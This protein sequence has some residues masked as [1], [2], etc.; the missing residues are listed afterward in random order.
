MI[1]RAFA[2]TALCGAAGYAVLRAQ[3]REQRTVPSPETFTI[4]Q[5]MRA[6]GP[7]AGP[8]D[9][10]PLGGLRQAE[11]DLA[12]QVV[13]EVYGARCRLHEPVVPPP[14]AWV[15]PRAQ[16]DADAL[17][18]FLVDH[19]P[20]DS[21][22]LIAITD[23][24]MFAAGRPYVFGYGHLRDRVAV[25]SMHRMEERYYGRRPRAPLEMTRLY[26]ALV[27]ELGHTAGNPHC[28][29]PG[30]VMREVADLSVLDG[31]TGLYCPE[32]MRRTRCELRVAPLAPEAQF[33]LGGALL[34]RRSF[35]RAVMVLARAA[36]GDP[37]NAIYQ[38]DLGVAL[39][40]RGDRRGALAAFQRAR[41]L[42]PDLPQPGYN[43]R[44]L[45]RGIVAPWEAETAET[46]ATGSGPGPSS[47]R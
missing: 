7:A 27:H 43:L 19:F 41:R 8:I 40:R 47:G 2:W 44:L 24:D 13:T 18:G 6:S 22:R 1:R 15:R 11:L 42:R 26:K 45:E 30:C 14:A 31:L 23:Q 46:T 32:C 12:C 33:S 34:R 36:N 20:E 3:A 39:L 10:V 9:V 38:N 28:S 4:P 16:L 21:S 17:L 37:R 25:V 5:E 29:A 35:D